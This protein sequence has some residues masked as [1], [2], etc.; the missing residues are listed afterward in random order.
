LFLL[1][2]RPT[3]KEQYFSHFAKTNILRKGLNEFA[4]SSK[5]FRKFKSAQ[6]KHNFGRR[7]EKRFLLPLFVCLFLEV[8][9]FTNF[10]IKQDQKKSLWIDFLLRGKSDELN[11]NIH[12]LEKLQWN[13]PSKLF[14][15]VRKCEDF[16]FESRE[17]LK[18]L[19]KL[20]HNPKGTYVD[21]NRKENPETW[22]Q[23][24]EFSRDP[25]NPFSEAF[26]NSTGAFSA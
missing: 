16:F 1:P 24:K 21:K 13:F 8:K 25:N 22:M 6:N 17:Y 23:F 18:F 9:R 15:F 3:K 2:W 14:L 11:L 5:L 26:H 12:E 7:L 10:G 20:F 19:G 4:R